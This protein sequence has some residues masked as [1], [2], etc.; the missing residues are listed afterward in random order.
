VSL[1]P[2][3]GVRNSSTMPR[4]IAGR[5]GPRSPTL[6][7]HRTYGS[8]SGGSQGAHEAPA[9]E[10]PHPHNRCVPCTLDARGPYPRRC[11][12]LLSGTAQA[13]QPSCLRLPRAS[14]APYRFRSSCSALRRYVP[15]L[16][17]VTPLGAT[18][19]RQTDR[20]P[21]VRRVTFAP[22]TRRIY[23]HAIRVASGFESPGPLAHHVNASY[24]VRVPQ[25]GAL[26][27]A[28]FPHHLTMIR[29]LFS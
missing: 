8:V 18:S 6:P 1:A 5:V 29:L 16:L 23:A 17:C 12:R 11:R 3:G 9:H 7:H 13:S 25:A 2:A 15:R 19:L 26:L 21:G 28:A 24:A 20:S 4:H 22:H 10:P 14:N 27:T